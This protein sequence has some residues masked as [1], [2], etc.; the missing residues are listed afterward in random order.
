MDEE[1]T[2]PD[3]PEG[4]SFARRAMARAAELWRLDRD[5]TETA[6]L[7]VSELATNAIRHG[8][9]PVRLSL[10]LERDRLRVEVTDSSPALPELSHPSP[11]QVGGRGLQ[12]V[13]QLAATWGAS[14][15]PRRLGKTVWFELTGMLH[16]R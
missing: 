2:L 13:Q 16:R 6:L 9:P 7:L 10:R 12:I 3:G 4:A 14:S 5:M 1:V 8:S 11:D 15:S